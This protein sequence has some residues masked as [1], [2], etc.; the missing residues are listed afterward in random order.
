MYE[1]KK[2]IVHENN[3]V[4]TKFASADTK[5]Y[6]QF[7]TMH[8]LRPCSHYTVYPA[9]ICLLKLNNRNT[10]K[11]CEICSKLT[12]KTPERR[13]FIVNFEHISHLVLVFL[14]LTLNI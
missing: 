11:S 13:Q 7:Y 2:Y 1:N 10:R 9:G 8:S 4:C 3:T 6:D 12:I 5:R 14:L